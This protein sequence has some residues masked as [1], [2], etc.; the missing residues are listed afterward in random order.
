MFRVRY[1]FIYPL[2][3]S[4]CVRRGFLYRF[5]AQ[6]FLS[7]GLTTALQLLSTFSWQAR[8][9]LLLNSTVIPGFSLL[10]I[11]EQAFCILLDMNMFSNWAH[12]WVREGVALFL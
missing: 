11:Q 8:L 7:T 3:G 2:L 1:V 9:L 5:R 10:E 6:R 4:S 12:S